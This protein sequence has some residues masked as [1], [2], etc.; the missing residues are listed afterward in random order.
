MAKARAEEGDLDAEVELRNLKHR[1]QQRQEAR[2]IRRVNGR[3]KGGAITSVCAPDGQGGRTEMTTKAE[4]ER[5]LLTENERWFNQAQDTPF[6]QQPLFDLVG[7]LGVEP[8]VQDILDGSFI[9]P[10]NADNYALLLLE[11][12]RRLLPPQGQPT[13]EWKL[14]PV[15]FR[16]SW[17]CARE[18]TASGPSGVTFAHFKAG[19]YDDMVSHFDFI[20][21]E[22]PFRSGLSPA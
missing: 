14:D 7:K 16:K 22:L 8:V 21:A 1:E 5:A 6:M 11:Q 2:M 9:A 19:A 3:L 17:R 18:T 4:M 20:M 10:T 13:V 12:C 15:D